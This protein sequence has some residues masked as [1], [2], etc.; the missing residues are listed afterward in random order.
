MHMHADSWTNQQIARKRERGRRMAK[1]R[2]AADRERR[3]ALAEAEAR[4]PLRVPGRIIQRVIVISADQTA[5]EIIRREATSR[6]E[7]NRMKQ[8]AGL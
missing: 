7:W 2:W 1:A 5:V 6:R 3:K 8:Q 4:D